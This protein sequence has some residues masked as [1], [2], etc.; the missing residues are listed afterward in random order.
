MSQKPQWSPA[1][2]AAVK[3]Q[4]IKHKDAD[5]IHIPER[6][7]NAIKLQVSALG[8]RRSHPRKLVC[9]CGKVFKPKTWNQKK[10]L[11]CGRGK[12]TSKKNKE[13]RAC[14]KCQ[15]DF[16]SAGIYNRICPGCRDTNSNIGPLVERVSKD[17]KQNKE[18]L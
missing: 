14:L 18:G 15:D 7:T 9:G 6:S 12:A 8:L 11:K 17:Y 13:K 3:T 4:W 10:C 2:L 1:E 16:Y 5:K